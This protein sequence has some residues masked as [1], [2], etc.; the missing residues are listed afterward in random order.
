[1]AQNSRPLLQLGHQQLQRIHPHPVNPH[2]ALQRKEKRNDIV[3]VD[4]TLPQ[5]LSEKFD[6]SSAD[7]TA[8]SE[9]K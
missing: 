3:G 5:Q 4:Q 7:L 6:G 2:V 1:L 9:A 8:P